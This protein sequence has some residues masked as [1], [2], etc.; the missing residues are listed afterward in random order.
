MTADLAGP[1]TRDGNGWVRL[2]VE[3][4]P[5]PGVRVEAGRV[6]YDGSHYNW[7]AWPG[8]T[9]EHAVGCTACNLEI[10]MSAVDDAL[11]GAEIVL[12]ES[13]GREVHVA[14][15]VDHVP[16]VTELATIT[17][18]YRNWRGEERIRT[19]R[20]LS[21]RWVAVTPWH[22]DPM[23]ILHAVDTEKGEVRDFALD[24]FTN[25]EELG[26]LLVHVESKL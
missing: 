4:R 23:W 6:N 12:Q 19:L 17:A 5:D 11:R 1:W 25:P 7:M 9:V 26:T 3:P 15:R 14:D 13:G 16:T 20:P 10:A 22:P 18:T 21:L 2:I 8:P 24:R